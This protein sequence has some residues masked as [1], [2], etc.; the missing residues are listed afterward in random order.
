MDVC[1]G[2]T[3]SETMFTDWLRKVTKGIIVLV[4]RWLG[5]LGLSANAITV[6]GCVLNV[7]AAGVVATGSLRWGGIGLIV[8]ASLDAIDGT[9]A[10]EMGSASSFG[11]FLDSVLDRVSESVLLLG[12]AWWYIARG[13]LMGV[14]LAYVVIAG[15]LTVSYT[16]ARAEGI[17]IDCKVGFLTRVE[18]TLIL[19]VALVMGWPTPALWIL[20]IGTWFTTGHRV[21]YVYRQT[22]KAKP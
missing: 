9:L 8:A 16:R 1:A 14:A 3:I 12:L 5:R 19:I 10:R 6:L 20:A 15:S 2:G 17:G 4:A 21:V 13:D 18:R 7:V 22:Q 11:A